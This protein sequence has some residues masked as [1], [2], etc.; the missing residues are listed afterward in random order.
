MSPLEEACL[1]LSLSML[2]QKSERYK[3][4]MESEGALG[5]SRR[6]WDR[7]LSVPK[8]TPSGKALTTPHKTGTRA[9]RFQR[10]RGSKVDASLENLPQGPVTTLGRMA[11]APSTHTH[12]PKSLLRKRALP[13]SGIYT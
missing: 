13:T 9:D 8:G 4:K 6:S 2:W 3:S 7:G 1:L 11:T 12:R 10:T 5:N